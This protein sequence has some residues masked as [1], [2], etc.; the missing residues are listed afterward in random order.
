MLLPAN[1]EKI[2]Q[3]G[4]GMKAPIAKAR[5]S[6]TLASVIDGPTSTSELLILSSKVESDGWRFTACTNIHMLS[7]PT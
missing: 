7:T 1:I 4:M 2:R 3:A 5:I 6:E